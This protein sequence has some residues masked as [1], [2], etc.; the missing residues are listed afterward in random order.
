MCSLHVIKGFFGFH[1]F[2][3]KI[4]DNS[5]DS[6]LYVLQIIAKLCYQNCIVLMKANQIISDLVDKYL[7]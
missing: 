2:F 3:M 4:I 5:S 1:H 6:T 7:V